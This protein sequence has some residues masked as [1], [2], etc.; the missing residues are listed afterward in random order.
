MGGRNIIECPHCKLV[1]IILL[2]IDSLFDR[3]S[4][5]KT[6]I[7]FYSKNVYGN[8]LEYVANKG[9]ADIIRQLTGKKTIDSSIRKLIRDLSRGNISFKRILK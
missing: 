9:D 4:I 3:L 7:E 5:M 8:E 2:T 6:T 1:Q